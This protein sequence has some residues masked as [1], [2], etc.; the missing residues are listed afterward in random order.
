MGVYN[1][2]HD[3]NGGISFCYLIAG[4]VNV[5]EKYREFYHQMKDV[6]YFGILIGTY[7]ALLIKD[8]GLIMRILVKDFRYFYDRRFHV[9]DSDVLGT[10]LFFLRNP[11]WKLLRNK[12]VSVFSSAKLKSSFDILGKLHNL[13]FQVAKVAQY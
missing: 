13:F 3:N 9:S 6:K 12:T 1:C 4:K 5:A 2:A 11:K 8:P 7:P 10:N